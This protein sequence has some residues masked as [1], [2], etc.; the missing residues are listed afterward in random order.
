MGIDFEERSSEIQGDRKVTSKLAS[1][2]EI[3]L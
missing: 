3:R 1:G 2:Y